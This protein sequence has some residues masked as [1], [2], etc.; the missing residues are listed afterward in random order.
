MHGTSKF[1]VSS[2]KQTIMSIEELPETPDS[3]D[4]SN[5]PAKLD[6][7]NHLLPKRKP[8]ALPKNLDYQ[9]LL[10]RKSRLGEQSVPALKHA[11]RKSVFHPLASTQQIAKKK[12]QLNHSVFKPEDSRDLGR[13]SHELRKLPSERNCSRLLSQESFTQERFVRDAA[14]D[15]RFEALLANTS[16]I[17]RHLRV[18]R[19]FQRKATNSLFRIRSPSDQPEATAGGNKAD[20]STKPNNPKIISS[21]RMRSSSQSSEKLFRADLA[22]FGATLQSKSITEVLLDL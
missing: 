1:N 12:P 19:A 8:Q 16:P 18:H 17:S 4:R 2:R 11:S 22:K 13:Q 10:G 14:V 20:P 5:A 6:P 21:G 3:R 15:P 9:K 7:H